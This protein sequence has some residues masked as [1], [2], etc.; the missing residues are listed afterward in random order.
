NLSHL[1][2]DD[3]GL[4]LIGMAGKGLE[5][6]LDL[7]DLALG[8]NEVIGLGQQVC[9]SRIRRNWSAIV[10][11][12]NVSHVSLALSVNSLAE[13]GVGAAASTLR[14]WQGGGEGLPPPQIP[15][16][17]NLLWATSHRDRW[18]HHIMIDDRARFS[19]HRGDVALD[20]ALGEGFTEFLDVVQQLLPVV[21]L[22][23]GRA[24]LYLPPHPVALVVGLR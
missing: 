19:L 11:C 22:S 9:Y 3:L 7:G 23:Q 24:A 14:L 20:G 17:A 18:L 4:Q 1:V 21:E 8:F 16:C 12:G 5:Q 13:L 10:K 2:R 6:C 15:S